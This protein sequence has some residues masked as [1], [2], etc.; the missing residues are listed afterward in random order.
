MLLSQ[1]TIGVTSSRVSDG[2]FKDS[3]KKSPED[4]TRKRKMGFE[5]LMIFMLMNFKC[6]AQTALR[7]FFGSLG[8]SMFMK[9]QSFSEARYKIRYEAFAEL[10]HLTG[11]T[12][13]GELCKT[14]HG[15]RV[16]AFDGSKVNLPADE[17][18]LYLILH[19]AQ[20]LCLTRRNSPYSIE[21]TLLLM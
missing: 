18:L 20:R 16:I 17:A 15:Y 1:K 7:R 6:T 19:I 21:A 2:S 4:F 13:L 3:A 14:W 8:V 11:E 5:E 9:Q 12:M 10:F